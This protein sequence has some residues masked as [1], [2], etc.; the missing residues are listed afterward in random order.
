MESPAQPAEIRFGGGPAVLVPLLLFIAAPL[1]AQDPPPAMMDHV[2]PPAAHDMMM[3]A[4]EGSGTAWL[5]DASPMAA[6][7]KT[8]GAW[9]LMLHGNGFIQYI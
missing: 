5:P 8:S 3:R 2:M 9:A 4:R 1:A 6:L 7:H